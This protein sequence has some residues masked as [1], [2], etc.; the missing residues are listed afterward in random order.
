MQIPGAQPSPAAGAASGASAPGLGCRSSHRDPARDGGV[1]VQIEGANR[2][3][4][5]LKPGGGAG[6]AVA[7]ALGGE[8]Q[9]GQ[10]PLDGGRTPGQDF[11]APCHPA[12]QIP[13]AVMEKAPQLP[14]RR[15]W[16]GH[17]D[18][19]V[20]GQR[21]KPPAGDP[22]GADPA[23]RRDVLPLPLPGRAGEVPEGAGQS[24]CA[25]SAPE[26]ARCPPRPRSADW[27]GRPGPGGCWPR[28]G[29]AAG[30]FS[31]PGAGLLGALVRLNSG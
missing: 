24:A 9:G 6:P 5:L 21:G 4:L 18:D 30:A 10:N 8:H 17:G 16:A 7:Q 28:A 22:T 14:L 26:C 13:H 29:R 20:A 12:G 2:R 3:P 19:G 11:P 15:A 31:R 1:G 27:A 25:T 23:G